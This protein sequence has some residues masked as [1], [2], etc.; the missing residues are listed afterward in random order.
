MIRPSVWLAVVLAT[1]LNAGFVFAAPFSQLQVLLPGES[2]APG[3]SSGKTGTPSPQTAGIPFLVTVNACDAS[4]TAVTTVTHTIR[5]L[6]SDAGASLPAAAQ[7]V[8]GTGTFLVILNADGNFT[9]FAHD[10]SDVTIPDGASSAV[11]SLLLQSLE[12]A[13]I[14]QAQT[15]GTPFA[16]SI[17]ARNPNGEV[18]SGFSGSVRLQ[19]NTSLG[20]GRISPASVTLSSGRWSGSVT[21]YRADETAPASGNSIVAGEVTGHPTQSGTSNGFVVH[22]G[23]F[24]RL[25]AVLPGQSPLPGSVS[26]TTGVPA[27]QTAGRSFTVG[28]YATDDYWNQVPSADAVR[29][30]SSTDPADT[31]VNGTL[32]AGYRQLSFTLMTVGTQTLTATD[33]TNGSILAMTSSGIQVVPSAAD[34][35]AFASI[36]SPRVAGVPFTITIR[37]TDASGNTVY[38]YAGDAVIGANTGTGTSTPTLIT[39]T[40]GVWSGPV[41]LFGAG[42]SVRL[43]CTDFSSPPRTGSSG[44][45]TVN[46]ATF[47]KLQVILPGETPKGGTA[48]GKDGTPNPQMAGTA[49]PVTI[50]AVDEFWNVVSGIGDRVALTSTDEFAG[51]PAETTLVSGQLVFPGILYESGNQTITAHDVTDTT[52]ADNTSG[53][54]NVVGG[55]FARVLVLAPG[56]SPAPGTETGRTGAAIDQSINYAFPLTVLATD[57][58]WNPVAG[59]TEVVHI[60]CEDA[61]AQVPADQALVNGRAE[62]PLRLAAGGYQQVTVS[63][64]SDPSKTG[65]ATQ[66]RAISS[67]FHLV[68][69]VTPATVQA[70]APFTL[71][72]KVT[73]DAGAVIS[74]INSSVTIE[75]QDANSHTLRPGTLSTPKFQLLGGQRSITET[76]TTS[77]SIVLVARDDAGNAPATSN[78]IMIA[79]G[80]PSAVRLASH[81]VWVGGNKRATLTAR[82]VDA[83]EN[84]VPDRAVTFEVVSGTG[85]VTP[86]DS[87]ADSNGNVRCEFLSPRQPEITRVRATSGAYSQDLDVQVA[88]VDPNAAGGTVT[89]FPNPFHPPTEGTTIA[90]KLDDHASVHIR[91]Y[92]Q[93]GELVR[94]QNFARAATGGAAGLNEWVWDGRN[95]KGDVIASGG[96]L[97]LIEAE[98]NANTAHVM[99]RKIAV[100]R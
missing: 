27:S 59:P 98:G 20:A 76:F 43:S 58:W 69:S 70:G 10:Q 53:A 51:L 83:Y 74:E 37:A 88:F 1:L 77:G 56:E 4:W 5:I 61:L 87:L 19:Q 62:M 91:I 22:P 97:A 7:L 38:D 81:P 85:S 29:L 80:P 42:S 40:A 13:S 66:V 18:V 78:T 47:K 54:I 33:Q 57:Q 55:P 90:Y 8:G 92:T 36:A 96:Y 39:F 14:S 94:E 25:Q 2:A 93:T 60:T 31:P 41:T 67:G 11:R 16:V 34:N 44:N 23:P 24:R 15:A 63:D 6:S 35:F 95:G 65:S 21:V 75:V 9:I 72:V 46:P 45:I 12:F 82:V 84:G 73:N 3:T 71:T 86:P 79:P 28:V 17:T 89:N 64:V 48:D 68:A 52:I 32:S 49:F 50:R 26:G 99:K 30:A 100:V